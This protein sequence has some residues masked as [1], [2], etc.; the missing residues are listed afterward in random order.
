MDIF[1]TFACGI[2]VLG[3]V[4][5]ILF[6]TSDILEKVGG[7]LGKLL[8]LP[9]DVIASTFQALATS[10]PEIVMAIIASSAFIQQEAWASLQHGEKASSGTLNMA[11]SA[12]DN[13]LGIGCVAMCFMLM[14][15]RVKKNDVIPAKPSTYM[16][17][18]FYIGASL[19]FATFL[20][21]GMITTSEAWILMYIGIVYIITQFFVPKMIEK[22]FGSS[23]D[24][25]EEEDDDDEDEKPIPPLFTLAWIKDLI[26]T[27]FTY[28]FL[29][30]LLVVMVR[31]A[32]GSTF[33][34]ATTGVVSLGGILLLI[35]S[36]V[37][38]F[39]E[40]MMAYR[41][42]MAD[43][44][45]ALLAMLFGSNVIDLAFAGY[46][47]IVNKVPIEVFTTGKMPHLLPYYIWTIPVLAIL[48]LGGFAT[49]RFKWGHAPYLV[50]FYLCYVISGFLL[51]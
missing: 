3:A 31:E 11:F 24:E 26:I 37:S 44:K 51:L 19:C 49:K 38:S 7:R 42:T 50:G 21:D 18:I 20:T 15:G 32:M 47:A 46:G 33:L 28:L 45:N 16:G 12:M 34:M 39:P 10:G 17:L 5:Y 8:K 25:G 36:Y 13:L 27:K 22:R 30:F 43:K 2:F 1:M 40:F 29:V 4:C 41:F 6:I 23:D 14:K 48:L 35:T 9:E